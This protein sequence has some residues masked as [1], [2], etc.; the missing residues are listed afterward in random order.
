[1]SI[2]KEWIASLM[3]R[4]NIDEALVVHSDVVVSC[5]PHFLALHSP[6]EPET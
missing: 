2:L 5:V 6:E 1:M 3:I 4:K